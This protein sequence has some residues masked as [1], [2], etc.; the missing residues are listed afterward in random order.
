MYRVNK[1]NDYVDIPAHRG[2]ITGLKYINGKLLVHT[3][4]TTFVMFPNPQQVSTDQVT[5][6]LTTGDFLSIPPQEIMETD[7]GFAGLQS[8]QSMTDTPYGHFWVDQKRR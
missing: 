6:Y 1:V 4:D 5:A 3:E 7:T 2:R 8:K